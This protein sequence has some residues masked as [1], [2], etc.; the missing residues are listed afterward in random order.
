MT[1]VKVKLLLLLRWSGSAH[2]D[3]DQ[4]DTVHVDSSLMLTAHIFLALLVIGAVVGA[5][6]ML[7]KYAAQ[8]QKSSPKKA[9]PAKPKSATKKSK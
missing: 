6:Y 9:Q 8:K 7:F 5:G 4:I 1:A 3:E 2:F